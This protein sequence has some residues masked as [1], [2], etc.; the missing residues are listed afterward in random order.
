MQG[1]QESSAK[2][3]FA[4]VAGYGLP[5]RSLVE[6]LSRRHI[7]YRVIELNPKACDRAAAGGVNIVAGDAADPRVLRQAGVERATLIA[8][9]IPDDQIVLRAISEIR[10]VN[11]TAHIIARCAFTSTGM[12]AL[13]RG[14]NQTI[15][16]EQTIA[17]QLSELTEQFFR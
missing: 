16:A 13:R 15:V 6:S 17:R 11:P 10:A 8:L 9:M 7:E 4:I 5:G 3:H 1:P 12:E 2:P 14:A